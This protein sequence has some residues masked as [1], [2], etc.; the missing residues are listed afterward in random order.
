MMYVLY[1]VHDG[2]Q[3]KQGPTEHRPI[4]PP[5]VFTYLSYSTLAEH[6]VDSLRR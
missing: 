1:S 6:A 3:Y 5:V 2:V 4:A